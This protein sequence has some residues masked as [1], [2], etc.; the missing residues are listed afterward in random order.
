[1]EDF[2]PP[3]ANTVIAQL[4]V[5][6]YCDDSSPQRTHGLFHRQ[7]RALHLGYIYLQHQR[8]CIFP[9]S[10]ATLSNKTTILN[11]CHFASV[12]LTIHTHS[13]RPRPQKPQTSL[14]HP[15]PY[16]HPS[17]L[18]NHAPCVIIIKST[19]NAPGAAAAPA[20]ATAE[21]PR[22]PVHITG[23]IHSIPKTQATPQSA[24]TGGLR[25]NCDRERREKERDVEILFAVGKEGRRFP[26]PPPSPGQSQQQQQGRRAGRA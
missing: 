26:K 2:S 11:R 13:P 16:T 1:M 10:T 12:Y 3:A 25:V 7:R 23:R 8:I 21:S 24:K 9:P 20:A 6:E 4:V 17:I 14:L 22:R 18:R 15:Q 19:S 5:N